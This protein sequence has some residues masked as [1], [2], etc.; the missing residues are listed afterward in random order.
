M[1]MCSDLCMGYGV[2]GTS[3]VGAGICRREVILL[4]CFHV[5]NSLGIN[6]RDSCGGCERR[7]HRRERS[8]KVPTLYIE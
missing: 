1:N 8:I 4:A 6:A 2:W 3:R 5:N 7:N